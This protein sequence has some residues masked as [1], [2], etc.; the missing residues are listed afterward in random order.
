MSDTQTC[1][2][3]GKAKPLVAFYTR[4]R[5]N[6]R[7]PS[8]Q[9]KECKMAYTE[10]YLASMTDEQREQRRRTK[11]RLQHRE[12]ARRKRI[13]DRQRDEDARIIRAMLADLLAK[14]WN[15]NRIEKATGI[16][17]NTLY[18]WAHDTTFRP[19][20]IFGRT[21]TALVDFYVLVKDRPAPG[22][23]RQYPPNA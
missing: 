1:N 6:G 12:D 11:L 14:G 18:R 16:D 20:R 13:T 21:L 8:R 10:R 22:R 2:G 4:K 9:C 17:R 7:V 19:A 23:R 5:G 15:L 3:C